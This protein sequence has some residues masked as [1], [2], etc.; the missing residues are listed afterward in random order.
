MSRSDREL[1][2]ELKK[3]IEGATEGM[4]VRAYKR[5]RLA[6]NL[7]VGK[8]YKYY[9]LASLTKIIFT[10]TECMRLFESGRLDLNKQVGEYLKWMKIEDVRVKDLLTH[11]AGA[12]WWK[13]YY[14][15]LNLKHSQ[16]IR[17]NC[18]KHLLRRE[19]IQKKE[20]SVYS[21]I[22]MLVLG[23]ILEELN[24]KP[25]FKV[26]E[27]L[28][29]SFKLKELDFHLENKPLKRKSQ[30]A[31]TENCKWRGHVLRGEVHDENTFALGGVAPHAG[32]FGTL[33]GVSDWFL[34][35]R[36]IL[37][38]EDHK[39]ITSK[40]L[41]V[42]A[43]RSIPQVQ[44]DWGLG[45]MLPSKSSASCGRFFA[46]SSVGHTGFTGTSLWFDPAAD[47]GV[48][49]L[50]NRV[51]PTRENRKFVE[52]RPVIHDRVYRHVMEQS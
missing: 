43:R 26:W 11:S 6:V 5:G 35:L 49:V 42:F 40:T 41:G 37:V 30:Y 12:E 32:L 20:K 38:G 23:M 48:I 50:S 9:D 14:E 10:V 52:L 24:E 7:E 29:E 4:C 39:M 44:G 1:Q 31:P 34:K 15:E 25:L 16:E 46:R 3:M 51:Y 47:L 22:G 17:W 13:P 8:T 28:K 36:K 18:L 21:D 33:N 27:N 45:F 19:E 2:A